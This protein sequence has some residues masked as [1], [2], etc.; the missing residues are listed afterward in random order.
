[1]KD[2]LSH[3]LYFRHPGGETM[4]WEFLNEGR[5]DCARFILS[6]GDQRMLLAKTDAGRSLLMVS[7][8]LHMLPGTRRGALC[9]YMCEEEGLDATFHQKKATG[10]GMSPLYSIISLPTTQ[11]RHIQPRKQHRLSPTCPP[12]TKTQA[13]VDGDQA[14]AV[15]WLLQKWAEHFGLARMHALMEEQSLAGYSALWWCGMDGRESA[16]RSLL[17]FGADDQAVDRNQVSCVEIARQ[18]R[19]NGVLAL[20]TEAGRAYFLSRMRRLVEVGRAVGPQ[21]E[22]GEHG[23][24]EKAE[25]NGAEDKDRMLKAVAAFVTRD[26]ASDLAMELGLWM[27]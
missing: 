27:R 14:E 24:D 21:M 1:M 20:Y 12:G 8:P 26:L 19:Q 15:T 6:L 13:A 18:R 25:G 11:D 16:A 17:A 4:M 5:V 10:R 22:E 23:E 2:S 9:V 7:S 3:I